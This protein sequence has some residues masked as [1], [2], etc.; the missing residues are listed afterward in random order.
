METMGLMYKYTIK[1]PPSMHEPGRKRAYLKL[2]I[3]QAIKRIADFENV[4]AYTAYQLVQYAKMSEEE[5][6]KMERSG[7]VPFEYHPYVEASELIGDAQ[8]GMQISV[9]NWDIL[10]FGIHREMYCDGGV[11]VGAVELT[12]FCID[13]WTYKIWPALGT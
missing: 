2:E 4:K 7:D 5:Y 10:D 8:K 9:R 1:L 3:W 6:L 13:P 12:A 11:R